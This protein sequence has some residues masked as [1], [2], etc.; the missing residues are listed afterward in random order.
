[1]LHLIGVPLL[2]AALAGC[3]L[4]PASG[5]PDPAP[6]A[7]P[8]EDA[9][10]ELDVL[11]PELLALTGEGSPLRVTSLREE[12]CLDPVMDENWNRL[13]RAMGTATGRYEDHATAQAAMDTFQTYADSNGWAVDYEVRKE[14]DNN[15]VVH[16]INYTK[17]GLTLLAI[18]DHADR[19][20]SRVVQLIISTPCAENPED[21][22]MIRSKLDPEYGTSSRLYDSDAEKAD[23]A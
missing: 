1:M 6:S 16:E 23:P 21:H 15:G 17:D 18:Y 2:L 4:T 20:D 3:A 12:S 19:S 9:M 7:R 22:Q 11:F 13:T 8:A 10:P 5:T 14:K